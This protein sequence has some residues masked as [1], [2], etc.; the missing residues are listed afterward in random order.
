V[1]RAKRELLDLSLPHKAG[2]Y[3]TVPSRSFSFP[4]LPIPCS[5]PFV[6]FFC[7]PLLLPSPHTSNFT[8]FILFT[9]Y[10][11]PQAPYH[12]WPSTAPL[13][14]SSLPS[15]PP[16]CL[17]TFVS[18]PY[19]ASVI[20][21]QP[22]LPPAATPCS[23]L[24]LIPSS[25]THHPPTS[26]FCLTSIA[27]P[28]SSPH[29]YILTNFPR[30]ILSTQGIRDG[31]HAPS[32]PLRG[33]RPLSMRRRATRPPYS[34]DADTLPFPRPASTKRLFFLDGPPWLCA[35]GERGTSSVHTRRSSSFLANTKLLSPS[36]GATSRLSGS[37]LFGR[38]KER[39]RFIPSRGKA[40]PFRLFP[41][42]L[43]DAIGSEEDPFFFSGRSIPFRSRPEGRGT[44][45]CFLSPLSNLRL[46]PAKGVRRRFSPLLACI[47]IKGN[48][49]LSFSSS[50]TSRV[51]E[52]RV[53]RRSFFFK[54]HAS[55][56]S[57]VHRRR[58]PPFF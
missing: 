4:S 37:S 30:A 43:Q 54:P 47:Q 6:L 18:F 42:L 9:F 7:T 40:C 31:E 3:L 38:Q 44:A 35:P 52:S 33:L 27:P 56:P 39:G 16:V 12:Q 15:Q 24:P 46:S 5:F 25:L 50:P 28:L 20:V 2:C 10:L 48:Q 53:S 19:V 14:H 23:L 1:S 34:T 13:R 58:D 11:L 29:F 36:S 49:S 57:V 55:Y 26:L 22:A 45:V 51:K 17:S 8:F 21:P 41:A 32:L